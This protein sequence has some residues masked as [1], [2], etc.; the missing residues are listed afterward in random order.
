M[1]T[2]LE[3]EWD[4]L[5]LLKMGEENMIAD[6]LRGYFV[7]ELKRMMKSRGITIGKKRKSELIQALVDNALREKA[8]RGSISDI[9]MLD[10]LFDEEDNVIEGA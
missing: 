8:Q 4:A 7:L 10:G 6:T 1:K 5:E 2:E 3:E 9:E